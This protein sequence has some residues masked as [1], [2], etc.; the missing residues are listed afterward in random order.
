M[1]PVAGSPISPMKSLT[2]FLLY[3][4]PAFALSADETNAIQSAMLDERAVYA[5][6]VST[7]RVTTISFPSALSAIDAAG[8]STDPK[9]PGPFQLAHTRGASFFSIRALA[10]NASANINVRW[11]KRTYVFELVESNKPVL[12]LILE[13]RS[14]QPSVDPAP[15]LS[16]TQLLALLDKAKAFPLLK[17][18]HP[19]VVSDVDFVAYGNKPSISDFNDYEIRLD[20][21]YRFNKE[22]TLVFRASLKNKSAQ[23]ITYRPDSLAV[24]IGNRVYHQSVSDA[25]GIIPSSA[26]TTVYFAITGTPDGGRNELSL[27]NNFT[28]LI[29]RL[30]FEPSARSDA[31]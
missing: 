27:K 12:S 3:L 24:R 22:D 17:R 5:V 25:S 31:K 23:Q 1:V 16:P 21:A 20:E 8:V 26:E 2:D 30:P 18:H 4:L 14:T 15:Q 9:V 11:N 28:V 19:D 13:D 6:A 7:N 29:E 10:P